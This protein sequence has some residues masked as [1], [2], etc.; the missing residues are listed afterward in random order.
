MAGRHAC[1]SS[2]TSCACGSKPILR[3]RKASRYCTAAFRDDGFDRPAYRRP[4]RISHRALEANGL[5]RC[6]NGK[7]GRAVRRPLE[8]VAIGQFHMG[9]EKLQREKLFVPGFCPRNIRAKLRTKS[10]GQ[11]LICLPL[12]KNRVGCCS[13][14]AD[15]VDRASLKGRA[16]LD[17]RRF[18]HHPPQTRRQGQAADPSRSR[19]K[20]GAPH[21]R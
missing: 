5:G 21:S 2:W 12:V 8:R 9:G 18:C 1:K 15:G 14:F 17:C 4:N 13:Q 20:L 11:C 7:I 3:D 19:R 16:Q 10:R 6:P